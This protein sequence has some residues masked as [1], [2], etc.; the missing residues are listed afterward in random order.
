MATDETREAYQE[1]WEA[2][3]R[4]L[5]RLHAFFFEGE[6]MEP[7]A[8]KGLINREARAKEHYDRARRRLLG[9]EE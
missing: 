8:L 9:I 3:Q 1:A 7:P 6:R 2:W 5:E 4:Q